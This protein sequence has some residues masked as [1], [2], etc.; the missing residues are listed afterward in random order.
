MKGGWRK[1]KK[2]KKNKRKLTAWYR[3]SSLLISSIQFVNISRHEM[4][5]QATAR[6]TADN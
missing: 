2:K 6:Q 1:K 3:L 5:N 4:K